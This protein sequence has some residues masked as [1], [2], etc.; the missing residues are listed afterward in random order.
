VQALVALS[1]AVSQE[2]HA[3]VTLLACY[4]RHPVELAIALKPAIVLSHTPR[5]ILSEKMQHGL[6]MVA[7]GNCVSN[8]DPHP[9]STGMV[10]VRRVLLKMGA[11]AVRHLHP[12]MVA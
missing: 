8:M 1:I 3:L 5:T 6:I 9:A 12:R 11:T 4:D 10:K 7:K 2:L